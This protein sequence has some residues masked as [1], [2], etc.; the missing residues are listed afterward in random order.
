[1]RRQANCCH[2]EDAGR[3]WRS[4]GTSRYKSLAGFSIFPYGD[5]YV[6]RTRYALRGD[7][8]FIDARC[9]RQ[10]IEWRKPYIDFA[11]QKYRAV[12]ISTKC[13]VRSSSV[14]AS[15]LAGVAIPQI[16]ERKMQNE[17]L[18]HRKRSPFP[19]GEGIIGEGGTAIAV[20]D[21]EERCCHREDAGRPWRSPG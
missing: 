7:R 20:T 10:H 16:K 4:P 19:R 21:E 14:I 2:C 6:L 5:R 9:R 17:N 3:P 15:L 1:M 18:I 12:G 13:K 11:K 8:D